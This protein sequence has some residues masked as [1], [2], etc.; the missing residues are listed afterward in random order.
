MAERRYFEVLSKSFDVLHHDSNTS[1]VARPQATEAL[2]WG[3][4]T[5]SFVYCSLFYTV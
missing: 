1:G 4:E 2:A 3:V 5:N